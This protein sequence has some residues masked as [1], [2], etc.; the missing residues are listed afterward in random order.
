MEFK[1]NKIRDFQC[2]KG[3]QDLELMFVLQ[4]LELSRTKDDD[5]TYDIQKELYLNAL[6]TKNIPGVQDIKN[7]GE[8]KLVLNQH[9]KRLN[10]KNDSSD[11]KFTF[12]AQCISWHDFIQD[13]RGRSVNLED[14]TITMND[15][16]FVKVAVE[17]LNNTEQWQVA[18]LNRKYVPANQQSSATQNEFV[19][20][21]ISNPFI[22]LVN[23]EIK[24]CLSFLDQDQKSP[25][26]ELTIQNLKQYAKTHLYCETMIKTCLLNFV[27]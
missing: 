26:W 11:T 1:H 23:N 9:V 19:L 27:G 17:W 14:Y 6:K 24:S 3:L 20:T 21:P 7:W 18:N 16:T 4:G 22:I 25:D 5:P 8:A 15:M 10:G 13:M 2:E 12:D